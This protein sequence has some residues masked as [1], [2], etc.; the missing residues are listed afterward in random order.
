M[1]RKH[2]LKTL[3]EESIAYVDGNSIEILGGDVW[4]SSI[5]SLPKNVK[6]NNQGSVNLSSLTSSKQSYLGAEREF[7]HIDGYTMLI[8]SERKQGD[9]TI[10]RAKYFGGGAIKSL[11]SC[12]VAQSGDHSA[13]GNTLKSAIEDVQYKI[14]AHSGKDE[15]IE[16][17][18]SSQQVTVNDF[19]VITGACREG[20]RQH[21]SNRRINMDT[22]E[23]L[24]LG[25]ALKAMAGSSFGDQFR[26]AIQ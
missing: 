4:L 14:Q 8:T 26:Q 24:P 10:L 6:F 21:L 1:N 3:D 13:H 12:F 20:M 15:A 2:F 9:L 22:I 23:F 5:K 11:N 19:R 18:K 7:R 25:E 16:R 17:V